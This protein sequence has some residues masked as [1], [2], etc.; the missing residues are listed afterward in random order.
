[1]KLY[2]NHANIQ[3]GIHRPQQETLTTKLFLGST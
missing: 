2:K 1:M 3:K